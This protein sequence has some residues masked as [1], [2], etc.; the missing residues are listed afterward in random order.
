MTVD[1]AQPKR[2]RRRRRDASDPDALVIGERDA[3]IYDCP[4]CSRPLA[5]GNTRCPG[6]GTR[7][8]ARVQA[9]R[10]LGFLALG[11]LVGIA[12]GGVVGG[13]VVLAN[14][15]ATVPAASTA[16]VAAASEPVLGASAAPLPSIAVVPAGI[17]PAAVS[18][19][20]QTAILHQRIATDA[21]RLAVALAAPEPASVE[22]ARAVRA[23]SGD[24]E[25]GT[26]L[27]SEVARWEDAA[28]LAD[29]LDAFY[30]E[31][32]G[33][34][35]DTLA[36]T[37]QSTSSYVE[38]GRAMLKVVSGLGSL[39]RSSRDLA[40]SAGVELPPVVLPSASP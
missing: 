40:T 39:D 14:R 27:T 16:P 22:I 19:L 25:F 5:N 36:V 34:A 26:R 38:S 13:G 33:T 8:I 31:I 3:N 9:R 37:L 35:K 7:L 23:L 30:V 28:P 11:S 21:D 1:L 6:C 29:D 24:A 2:S 10:A 18:A 20:R 15:P 12:L 4:T 32:A 17:P